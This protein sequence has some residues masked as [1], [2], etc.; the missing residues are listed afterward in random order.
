[1]ALLMTL[2][3]MLMLFGCTSFDLDEASR[4]LD[5]LLDP[6]IEAGFLGIDVSAYR[7]ESPDQCSDP[8]FGPSQGLRPSVQYEV[9]LALLGDQAGG[10]LSRVEKAW[11]DQGLEVTSEQDE[12]F[13]SR[14]VSRGFY[15][16]VADVSLADQ[17][18]QIGGTGPCADH[19]EG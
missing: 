3:S 17:A 4:E 18:G 19:P 8:I 1:M 6:A 14:R 12:N 2:T 7:E 13:I 11:K 10:F 16:A 5:E 9:P 15:A